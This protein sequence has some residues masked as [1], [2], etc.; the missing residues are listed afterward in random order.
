MISRSRA[1]SMAEGEVAFTRLYFISPDSDVFPIRPA[2]RNPCWVVRSSDGGREIV[3]VI[4]A[5]EGKWLG[6]GIP[7]P[8]AGFSLTGPCLDH[9]CSYTWTS[10]YLNARDW[11]E[12]MGYPTEAIEYPAEEEVR[13]HVQSNETVMFYEIAHG[14]SY[15]FASGCIVGSSYENT[16]WSEIETWIASYEKKPFTFIGSC[17]GM[18]QTGNDTLSYEFRK[19]SSVNTATVGYCH[20]AG[21]GCNIC[22]SYSVD[23]QD[24]LFQYMALGYTV[25]Y[26]FDL[27]NAEVPTCADGTCM[28]LAGDPDFIPLLC[29]D[30]DGDGFTV[31]DDCDDTNPSIYPCAS[32]ICG[33]GVDGDCSGSDR[34]CVY[35]DEVEP[36]ETPA[37]AFDLREIGAGAGVQGYLCSTG[38]DGYQYTGDN[39]CFRFTTPV[40]LVS[41]I[42]T[43][44]WMNDANFDLWLYGGWGLIGKDTTISKPAVLEALLDPATDYKLK[45]V[46]AT[47]APSEYTVAF[48][49]CVDA[50]GDGFTE[51]CDGGDCDDGDASI[52]PGADEI[53]D[54]GLDNDCN[55]LI[56]E[57]ERIINGGFE[58]WTVSGAGGP[59]DNWD[60]SG[61]SI[62]ATQEGTTV[63]SGEYGTNLNWTTTSTRYLQQTDIAVTEGVDYAFSFWCFDDDLAGRVR[64]YVR[65]YEADNTTYISAS[66]GDYSV[67]QED[68]QFLSTGAITAPALAAWAHAE[69][70]AY[71]NSADWDGDATVYVDDA[72]FMG[73]AVCTP[74]EI[75]YCDTGLLG[76][77]TDGTHI[78]GPDGFWGACVQDVMPSEELCD[79][80]IDEDCD[81]LIDE[82][83]SIINGGFEDWTVSGAGGPPDNWD[84]SGDSI[85]AIQEGTTVYSGEYSTN[86]NWTTTSIRYLQQTDIAVIEGVDYAF[87]FWCFDDDLAG[88]VR[89]YVRWYEADNTTY[90]SA[91]SGDYS[92]DQE[93]WQFLSTGAITAPALAA[94]AHA[95]IR[96]YENSADWDG[97]ATVYIDDA[98]FMGSTL[99]TP[100]ETQYCDTGL[101]GVCADGTQICGLDGVWGACV[102]DE[103]LSEELCDNGIDDDCDGL[104]DSED[105]DCPAEFVIELEGFYDVDTLFLEFRVGTPEPATWANYIVL[106]YPAIQSIPLWTVPLQVIDPPIDYE[107]TFPFPRTGL[108]LAISGMFTV[109]GLKVLDYDWIDTGLPSR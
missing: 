106:T 71:D 20:M 5:V 18:C 88:R 38:H 50:D 39:D 60:L 65:W 4:D 45:V 28:R 49:L 31:F 98:S 100:G 73:S 13:S 36:N 75:Q 30:E 47:G 35:P 29:I 37:E 67:D 62:T 10:W 24:T 93:D 55:G 63:Y 102:Q 9:P 89:P 19:G 27:A 7:P 103:M 16:S 51:A 58:D 6:Y 12:T 76:V 92:I 84:L 95:E 42:I 77:C 43:L 46:G 3:T 15:H 80:G 96:A 94:W 99:C 56:D 26:A 69:I 83:E 81:G 33:D 82:T 52:N 109:A 48:T 11:F 86:L 40:A 90:I 61:D 72:S 14:D 79:N 91:S 104:T 54:D 108:V 57:I 1:E 74:G 2:P 85:T 44:D 32:E 34:A 66:S 25:G 41:S 21:E 101:L 59:P 68:W 17:D 107:V 70:R 78:C 23:W 87:G 8:Y 64:P 97:D 105:P 53:Y 22:W